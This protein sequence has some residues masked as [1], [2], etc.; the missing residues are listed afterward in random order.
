MDQA[1]DTSGRETH[2]LCALFDAPAYVKEASL[3]ER[4]GDPATPARAFADPLQRRFACHTKAACWLSAAFYLANKDQLSATDREQIGQQLESRIKFAGLEPE[5]RRLEQRAQELAVDPLASLPNAEFAWVCKTASGQ[6][7]RRLPLRNPHEVKT[8]ASWLLQY[9][10][11]FRWPDRREIAE[12]ILQKAASYGADLGDQ[13]SVLDRIAGYGACSTA[14]AAGLLEQRAR[15]IKRARQDLSQELEKFASMLR[16]EPAKARHPSTLAKVAEIVDQVD[17]QFGLHMQYSDALPRPEDALFPF[18]EK[19]ARAFLDEHVGLVNGS[20]YHKGD[21]HRLRTRE[22]REHLGD[23]IADAVTTNG[24]HVDSDK[25]A[26]IAATLP[27]GDADLFDRLCQSVGIVRV[28]KEASTQSWGLQD[29][30][31]ALFAAMFRTGDFA[32]A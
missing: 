28:T 23:S 32:P 8:A 15:L 12:R 21:M 25:V 29:S 27:R 19:T 31:L 9:R 3:S 6:T 20:V 4:C 7:Q 10:D 16:A 18:N 2:R 5:L 30:D 13:F 11:Q 24:V 14:T 1:R 22:L 17:H 26:E